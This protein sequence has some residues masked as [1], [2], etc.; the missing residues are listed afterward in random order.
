MAGTAL[1]EFTQLLA[2]QGPAWRTGPEKIINEGVKRTYTWPRLVKGKDMEEMIDGGDVITDTIFFDVKS[3]FQRYSPNA[4]FDYDN[5]QVGTTW[6]VPWAFATANIS[7]TK[8][9]LGLNKSKH[10]G[11]YRTQRYKKV[12]RQKHQ[13]LWTDVCNSIDSEFWAAPNAN[14]MEVSAPT[15]SRIPYSIPVFVNENSDASNPTATGV[16]GLP[17]PVAAEWSTNA[18]TVMGINPATKTK[19]QNQRES[20]NFAAT[21]AVLAAGI[22]PAMTKLKFKCS[23]DRLPKREE[24]SDKTTSP[25][26][27]LTNLEGISNYEV[28][29]RL[30]QDEF[31]GVGKMSGQDPNYDKPTFGG[32]PLDY[33]SELD[34]AAIYPT[35]STAGGFGTYDDGTNTTNTGGV[36]F[37]GPRYTWI[38]GEYMKLVMHDENYME[39]GD[40]FTPSAQPFT[41][42][43]VMDMWNNFLATSRMRHGQLYPAANITSA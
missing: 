11:K 22:F 20:Y 9:E 24:Y 12:L 43:Q 18:A 25:H 35:G 21:S 41:R 17:S 7:I 1:E 5:F 29:L 36:G 33:I 38:N 16:N 34:T 15:G 32:I 39:L 14:L 40:P 4:S 28:A 30:N 42:V 13:N 2:A 6:T 23:F 37:V 3:S 19:W 27:I 26:V 8:H 31:R 10:T